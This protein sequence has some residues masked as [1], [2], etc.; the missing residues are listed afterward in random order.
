MTSI[1]RLEHGQR[2]RKDRNVGNIKQGP[3]NRWHY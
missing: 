3:T 1:E 2:Q